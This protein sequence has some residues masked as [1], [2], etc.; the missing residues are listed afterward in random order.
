MKQDKRIVASK[1]CRC[2]L[3]L[4]NLFLSKCQTHL[5]TFIMTVTKE[6]GKTF[7]FYGCFPCV[8][9]QLI[10]VVVYWPNTCKVCAFAPPKRG[11]WYCKPC[12]I[13]EAMGISSSCT[14]P[15]GLFTWA[16]SLRT[17]HWWGNSEWS[18]HSLKQKSIKEHG[19]HKRYL[20]FYLKC[21]FP[22]MRTELWWHKFFIQSPELSTLDNN[23]T[24]HQ[25]IISDGVAQVL[26]LILQETIELYQIN[27]HWLIPGITKSCL[28]H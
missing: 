25:N 11:C 16:G 13:W 7:F 8:Y 22:T 27:G 12:Y 20:A 5:R 23:I 19:N 28:F 18:A 10:L 17:P 9:D 24:S 4:S 3:F 1:Q 15:W 21:C 6:K 14:D 26:G 2:Y